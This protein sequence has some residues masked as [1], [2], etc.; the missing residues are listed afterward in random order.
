MDS[1]TCSGY[2][3]P[4]PQM[5]KLLR[6]LSSRN[7]NVAVIL[8]NKYDLLGIMISYLYEDYFSQNAFGMRLQIECMYYWVLLLHYGLASDSIR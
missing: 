2:N 7:R 5:V 1:D 4:L 3:M 8:L 6:V